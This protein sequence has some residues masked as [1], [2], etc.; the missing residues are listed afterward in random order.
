MVLVWLQKVIDASL[1]TIG[2]NKCSKCR[3]NAIREHGRRYK[4]E[5]APTTA[6]MEEKAHTTIIVLRKVCRLITIRWDLGA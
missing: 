3:Y 4:Y 2:N 5:Y 1:S 6:L